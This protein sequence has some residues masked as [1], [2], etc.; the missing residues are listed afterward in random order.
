MVLA[1]QIAVLTAVEL[2]NVPQ[3]TILPPSCLNLF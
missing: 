2:G 1:L 3:K